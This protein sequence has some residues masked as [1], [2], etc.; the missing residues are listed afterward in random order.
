[1]GGF[2][3]YIFKYGKAFSDSNMYIFENDKKEQLII[4]EKIG[5]FQ[6]SDKSQYLLFE[7]TIGDIQFKNYVDRKSEEFIS[8]TNIRPI[9]DNLG[10]T[11]QC[12][13][14]NH[15][16]LKENITNAKGDTCIYCDKYACKKCRKM[17][18]L[19]ELDENR[20]C[21]KCRNELKENNVDI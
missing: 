11:V 9:V 5:K 8:L 15:I 14:C 10:N 13:G 3:K 19:I 16:V 20:L 7:Y 18:P 21:E 4:S 2:D 6:N 12:K 1:M 17:K